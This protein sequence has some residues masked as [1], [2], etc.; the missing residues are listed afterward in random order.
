MISTRKPCGAQMWSTRPPGYC[1]TKNL[2][3]AEPNPERVGVAVRGPPVSFQVNASVGSI[4]S[5]AVTDQPISSR[6]AAVD[7]APYLAALVAT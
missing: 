4:V 1:W 3:T 2:I 5:P 6:P 7:S